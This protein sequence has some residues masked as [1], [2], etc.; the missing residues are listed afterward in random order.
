VAQSPGNVKVSV[1]AARSIGTSRAAAGVEDG[2]KFPLDH[3]ALS[4][5]ANAPHRAPLMSS[6][7]AANRRMDLIDRFSPPMTGT[8]SDLLVRWQESLT[9][10][11]SFSSRSCR[12]SK[13]IWCSWRSNLSNCSRHGTLQLRPCSSPARSNIDSVR[14]AKPTE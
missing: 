3:G 12:S 11:F 6:F 5:R 1:Q 2:R 4:R 9:A 13:L 14:A 8:I 7:P 10:S